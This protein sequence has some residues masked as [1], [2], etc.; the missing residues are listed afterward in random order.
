MVIFP[1][2]D[3]YRDGATHH[4]KSG[5]ARMAMTCG[6]A[7]VH[8]PIFPM[9]IHHL[10]GGS[11]TALVGD[12]IDIEEYVAANMRDNGSGVRAL[13]SRLY[14]EVSGLHE[15][16]GAT[17]EPVRRYRQSPLKWWGERNATSERLPETATLAG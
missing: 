11:A 13:T 9:A 12:A 4:F 6:A 7:G 8:L 5:A 2:G 17:A 15:E 3:I 16:L 10:P 1:E 14:R